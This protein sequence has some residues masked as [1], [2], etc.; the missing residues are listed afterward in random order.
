MKSFINLSESRPKRLR[1]GS[2]CNLKLA[3]RHSLLSKTK[4]FHTKNG[5]RDEALTKIKC[6]ELSHARSQRSNRMC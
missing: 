6:I 5:S 2:L 1:D 4:T 3:Y